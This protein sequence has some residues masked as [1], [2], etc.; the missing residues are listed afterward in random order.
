MMNLL[1]G[2]LS[3]ELR[4]LMTFML[5]LS[6]EVLRDK[7]LAFLFLTP[8]VGYSYKSSLQFSSNAYF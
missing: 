7:R 5:V 1:D 2:F 8:R 6:K 4:S 3:G